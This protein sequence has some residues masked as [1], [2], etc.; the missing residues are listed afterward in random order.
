[1]L[2]ANL[3]NSFKRL[4][5]AEKK[6]AGF[7]LE[8][9]EKAVR[10]TAREVAEACQTAQSAVVR[11]SKTLGFSG[12]RELKIE[13]AASLGRQTPPKP[14]SAEDGVEDIFHKVFSSSIKTLRDT[15]T[16]LDFSM[17]R[18]L[19]EVL[20]KAERIHIFGVGT[21]SPIAQDAAYRFSQMGLTAYAYS[22]VLFM[23]VAAGNMKKGDVAIGVSHSG[24]TKA[25]VD[26]VLRAK[27]A[28]AVTVALTS[29]R[30]SLLSKECAY[31]MV[32]YSDEENYPVEAV[33]ARVA[34]MCVMDALMMALGTKRQESL[35]KYRKVR[36]SALSSIRYKADKQKKGEAVRKK[37]GDQK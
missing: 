13:L 14:H 25:V 9:P 37:K 29:F 24:Q 31:K 21:S 17:L 22:D 18:E 15:L 27:E 23:N 30:E 3:H 35:M 4:T 2:L 12:F 16:L 5:E 36:D 20:E 19:S 10:M 1:M 34:H 7:M 8:N 33:S 26:A 6:I 11:L 28:G 32:V